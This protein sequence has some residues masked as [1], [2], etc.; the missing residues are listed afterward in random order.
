MQGKRLT[1]KRICLNCHVDKSLDKYNHSTWH[2]H[3]DGFLCHKCYNRLISNPK[4]NPKWK[5]RQLQWTPKG[6]QIIVKE[7]PRTG[8]CQ[9][10]GRQIGDAYV[11]FW[12]QIKIIKETHM[13]HIE[14]HEDDPLKDTVELCA[15]CHARETWAMREN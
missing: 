13:H 1:D 14:Y 4:S 3:K 15:S 5:P 9:N 12:G 2:K 10:C 6:R 7:D 11:N 8:M